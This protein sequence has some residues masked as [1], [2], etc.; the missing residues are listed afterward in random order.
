MFTFSVAVFASL[1]QQRLEIRQLGMTSVNLPTATKSCNNEVAQGTVNSKQTLREERAAREFRTSTSSADNAAQGTS[2]PGKN[3]SSSSRRRSLIPLKPSPPPTARVITRRE[4]LKKT[5]SLVIPYS[6]TDFSYSHIKEPGSPPMAQ[7]RLEPPPKSNSLSDLSRE[8]G[9]CE[10]GGIKAPVP[11][12]RR[13]KK[14]SSRA[15]KVPLPARPEPP[16]TILRPQEKPGKPPVVTPRKKSLVSESDKHALDEGAVTGSSDDAALPG[17][18]VSDQHTRDVSIDCDLGGG[19]DPVSV[20]L[21]KDNNCST[22]IISCNH[23][24]VNISDVQLT[25]S[26][27]NSDRVTSEE[28]NKTAA[29]NPARPF[30]PLPPKKTKIPTSVDSPLVCGSTRA[31]G[32]EVKRQVAMT[33]KTENSTASHANPRSSDTRDEFRRPEN[34]S[35]LRSHDTNVGTLSERDDGIV[36]ERS[37]QKLT[38]QFEEKF[39]PPATSGD[40]TARRHT[41]SS[42]PPKPPLPPKSP[43]LSQ[44]VK[45]KPHVPRPRSVIYP[46]RSQDEYKTSN[47]VDLSGSQTHSPAERMKLQRSPKHSTFGDNSEPKAPVKYSPPH[48]RGLLQPAARPLATSSPSLPALF[49]HP[50]PD[51]GP[52]LNDDRTQTQTQNAITSCSPNHVR[53]LPSTPQANSRLSFEGFGGGARTQTSSHVLSLHN[54]P[55][56]KPTAPPTPPR[57]SSM[58]DKSTSL[59]SSPVKNTP[60]H[61]TPA[62]KRMFSSVSNILEMNNDRGTKGAELMRE[63]VDELKS[64]KGIERD[65]KMAEDSCDSPREGLRQEPTEKSPKVQ[66]A[67]S[68][69]KGRAVSVGDISLL[70]GV[71]PP[72]TQMGFSSSNNAGVTPPQHQPQTGY[73]VS[74]DTSSYTSSEG[75]ASIMSSDTLSL[76][77]RARHLSRIKKWCDQPEVCTVRPYTL[78]MCVC[79]CIH[80]DL[81]IR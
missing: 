76:L 6:P 39:Q 38:T 13:K 15:L 40:T 65:G 56:R 48:S 60:S 75:R 33:F 34:G 31:N 47:A 8:N 26:Q 19:I 67:M 69:T 30:P 7:L 3:S 41:L 78:C 53:V 9:V 23:T 36:A 70:I 45:Q 54:S 20:L 66:S 2:L 58:T 17:V 5:T 21:E 10:S 64:V 29:E 24:A 55:V 25:T 50:R 74:S 43:S 27:N 1:S 35:V 12:P 11:P 81:H 72:Q 59:H 57:R 77:E 18:S 73:P 51:N 4:R 28:N 22:S 62:P 42:R 16:A 80:F 32:E 68:I 52:T 49:D 37:V 63:L 79:V 14:R 71:N 44:R 46:Q 61:S